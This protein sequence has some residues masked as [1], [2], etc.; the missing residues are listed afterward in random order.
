MRVLHCPTDVGGNSWGLSR[1]E[2]KLGIESDVMVFKS[3]W[4]EY[5]S[6]INLHLE[7]RSFPV[8]VLK[9]LQFF[10]KSINNYDVFHFN[11]GQSLIDYP[12]SFNYLDLPLLKRLEKKVIITFQGCDMRRRNYNLDNFDISC[13]KEC[14]NISCGKYD[15]KKAA[16]LQEALKYADRV[17]V[18]NPDLMH[19]SPRLEFMPYAS[20]DPNEWVLKYDVKK[21][22]GDDEI[23]ILHAPTSRSMK[24]TKYVLEAYDKLKRKGYPVKLMLAENIPHTKVKEYYSQADIVVDQLLAGWYGAFA[25]E[26]MALRKP[27][28]CYL[29]QCDL[30]KYILFKNKI[31]IVNTTSDTLYDMLVELIENPKLRRDIGEKSRKYVEDVHDPM[32]IARK[33]IDEVYVD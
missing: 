16:R 5:Q 25:V 15:D 8:K 10:R 9:V 19:Y 33:L 7:N 17:F 2:R 26:A 11:F 29:R 22:E 28:L 12:Y 21:N 32:K 13:C 23:K 27:V 1:A 20:V 18:L 31:P 4:F 30:D 14:D 24:G 3:R 6:D